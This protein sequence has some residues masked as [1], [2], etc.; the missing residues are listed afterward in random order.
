VTAARSNNDKR[1]VCNRVRCH[2]SNRDSGPS[3]SDTPTIHN[4]GRTADGSPR[5][6]DGSCQMTLFRGF[7][8][9]KW[10]L[11]ELVARCG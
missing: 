2:G 4:A 5:A 6:L 11:L 7:A 8:T 9:L 10:W 1:I 3:C